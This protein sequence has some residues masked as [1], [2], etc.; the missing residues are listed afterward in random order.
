M[1]QVPRGH[2]WLEGDNIENS[3]DSRMF[4]PVPKALIKSRV[5]YKVGHHYILSYIRVCFFLFKM[6]FPVICPSK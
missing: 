5:F 2:V 3:H 1:M 6:L 4:G